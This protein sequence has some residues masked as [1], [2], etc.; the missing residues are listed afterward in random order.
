MEAGVAVRGWRR[1][2][3][4]PPVEVIRG[5]G[6]TPKLSA[7]SWVCKQ[8]HWFVLLRLDVKWKQEV[9]FDFMGRN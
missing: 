6:V 5:I 3:L 7:V 9:S 1:Q 4:Q 2:L 8:E